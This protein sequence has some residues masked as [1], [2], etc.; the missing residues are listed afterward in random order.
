[1]EAETM[2]KMYNLDD[3]TPNT[4]FANFTEPRKMIVMPSNNTGFDCGLLFGKYP[5]RL[6]HLHSCE[7]LS[8]PRIV[9]PWELDNGVFVAFQSGK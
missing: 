7:R 9:I 4:N 2:N 3:Y 6:A 1:M 8:E 5:D